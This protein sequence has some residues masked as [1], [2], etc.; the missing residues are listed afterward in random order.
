MLKHTG[1]Q[2]INTERL[3]LRP[4]RYTDDNDMLAYWISDPNIQSLYSE[5]IYTTKEE[6][7]ELLDIYQFL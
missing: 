4:F 6:V 2:V 7:K 1:T 3:V 5:P